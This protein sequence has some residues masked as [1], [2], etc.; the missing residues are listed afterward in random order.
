V[1]LALWSPKGGS[2]TSV[3][4]AA[5]A[6]V[7]ARRAPARLADLAGDQPAILGLP[8]EPGDGLSRWLAAGPG[9]PTEALDDLV[10]P[11]APR[12]GLLPLGTGPRCADLSPEA[13]AA[14]GVALRDGPD[15]VLDAGLAASMPVAEAA[16]DVSDASI[17]VIR[18]CYLALRQA[19]RTPLVA[20][21]RGVVVVEEP[22][23]GL[24]APEVADILGLPVLAR[25]PFRPSVARAVDAGVL[26]ARL[27]GP[28]RAPAVALLDALGAV[29][30]AGQAA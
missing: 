10:L 7:L 6:L 19:V 28:L 8:P 9:A 26:A 29:P 11:A 18:G 1:L 23:R 27:P 15:T 20:R 4:A 30:E 14:L 25:F 16:V 22:A 12:L 2:G 17:V 13:G 5:T 24:G 3:V 21:A